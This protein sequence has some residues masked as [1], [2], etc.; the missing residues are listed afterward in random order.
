M[1]RTYEELVPKRLEAFEGTAIK[2]LELGAYH[3]AACTFIHMCPDV[4]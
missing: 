1:F 3:S 2:Q 4:W